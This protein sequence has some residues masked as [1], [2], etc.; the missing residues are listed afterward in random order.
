MKFY[1]SWVT[2]NFKHC[3][4]FYLIIMY[5]TKIN[6]NSDIMCCYSYQNAASPNPSTQLGAVQAAR[7]VKFK[8]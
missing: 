5:I 6:K 1:L 4:C 7:L 8:N 2:G 3:Y